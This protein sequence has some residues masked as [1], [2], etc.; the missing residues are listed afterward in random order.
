MSFLGSN[1]FLLPN[2]LGFLGISEDS[3]QAADSIEP[4]ELLDSYRFDLIRTQRL[5]LDIIGD[6]SLSVSLLDSRGTVVATA[7]SVNAKKQLLVAELTPGAYS[8][9]LS[10]SA[11]QSTYSFSL[12]TQTAFPLSVANKTLLVPAG[13]TATISPETLRSSGSRR[14][15]TGIVYKVLSLP[16]RGRME[17]DGRKLSENSYFTQSDIDQGRF[18]YINSGQTTNLNYGQQAYASNFSGDSYVWTSQEFGIDGDFEIVTYNAS[19]Q[20]I[21]QITNNERLDFLPII[22]GENIVWSGFDGNDYEVFLF[23][24][25]TGEIKQLTNNTWNDFAQDIKG[26]SVVWNSFFSDADVGAFYYDVQADVALELLPDNQKGTTAISTVAQITGDRVLWYGA[27]DSNDDAEVFLF[28]TKTKA[29]AQLTDNATNDFAIAASEDLV[30]WNSFDGTDTDVFLY[31]RANDKVRQLTN[32]D[33]N[34][35]AV[36]LDRNFV[37]FNEFDG[38]DSDVVLYDFITGDRTQITDNTAEDLAVG[39]SGDHVVWNSYS[40]N[41]IT[42]ELASPSV[43]SFNISRRTTTKVTSQQATA[44]AVAD[45]KIFINRI[46]PLSPNKSIGVTIAEIPRPGL[47]DSFEFAVTDGLNSFGNR[48]QFTIQMI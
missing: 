10:A 15:L 27:G 43:Y 14:S 13:E 39:I 19:T 36:G 24:A 25:E 20:N 29:N 16:D 7:R 40:R 8:I 9:Q 30:L 5:T 17:L 34:D 12:S 6:R 26:D 46:D 41:P 38:E 23:W 4:S 18:T 11:K 22:N 45:G 2:Y 42:Q 31:D 44:T 32:N 1:D 47:Q 3:I 21:T 35:Q 37:V 28:N 33:F 48:E